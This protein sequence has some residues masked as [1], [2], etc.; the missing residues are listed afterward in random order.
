[1]SGFLCIRRFEGQRLFI[2]D[3]EIRIGEV[4]GGQVQILVRT[5]NTPVQR[6]S[7]EVDKADREEQKKRW[8]ERKAN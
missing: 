7:K 3:A 6:P 5:E 4:R 1:M 2:G 8:L